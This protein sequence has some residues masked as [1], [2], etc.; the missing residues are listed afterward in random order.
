LAFAEQVTQTPPVVTDDCVARLRARFTP[1][2]I[3]ELAATAAWENYRA[4]FNCALG[5][6]GHGFYAGASGPREAGS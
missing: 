3:V 2:Q 1:P 5:V 6:E 4:R